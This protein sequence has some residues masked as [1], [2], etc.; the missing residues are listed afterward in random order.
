M[1][2]IDFR[3]WYAHHT[4]LFPAVDGWLTKFPDTVRRE[5]EPTQQA[6]LGAW[7]RILS[8]VDLKFAKQASDLLAKGQEEFHDRSFDCHP[9]TVRTIAMKLAGTQRR[10]QAAQQRSLDGEELFDCGFCRDTGIVEV[11][12]PKFL[13]WAVE[14]LADVPDPGPGQRLS[15][16]RHPLVLKDR[17]TGLPFSCAIAC[18]CSRGG[19]K[20]K[21]LRGYV[22]NAERHIPYDPFKFWEALEKMRGLVATRGGF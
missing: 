16:Q 12:V 4:S 2:M 17:P 7:A 10:A 20:Q 14:A 6:V 22:F 3:S 18:T 13:E 21:G 11:Y 8:D 19:P 15:W 5:G 9:R 1:I